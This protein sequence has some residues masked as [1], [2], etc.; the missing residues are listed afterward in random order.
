M[1]VAE[2]TAATPSMS[3]LR[4]MA[5]RTVEIEATK[6]VEPAAEVETEAKSTESESGTE[7]E[8]QQEEKEDELPV[9]IGRAHV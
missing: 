7:P 1:P 3:E 8:K 4:Q 5:G 6:T 2:Q 9:K